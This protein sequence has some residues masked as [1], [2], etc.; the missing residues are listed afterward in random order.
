VC[1]SYRT[2]VKAVLSQCKRTVRRG[3]RGLS[4]LSA[5]PGVATRGRGTPGVPVSRSRAHKQGSWV[6]VRLTVRL[7]EGAIERVCRVTIAGLFQGLRR[8]LISAHVTTRAQ[9]AHGPE[10]DAA[11][12]AL[13]VVRRCRCPVLNPGDPPPERRGY[14]TG[15]AEPCSPKGSCTMNR[16][17]SPTTLSAVIVPPW[18]ATISFAIARPRPAPPA[19][20]RALS[21]R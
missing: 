20:R 7:Q 10:T 19:L 18:A 4:S 5:D 21:A 6:S 2:T 9:L 3:L 16:L 15:S 14:V 8:L 1:L 17:P 12:Q 13:D 11:L